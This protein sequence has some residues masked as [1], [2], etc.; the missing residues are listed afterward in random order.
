MAT[1]SKEVEGIHG[2]VIMYMYI[3]LMYI[4]YNYILLGL[5]ADKFHFQEKLLIIKLDY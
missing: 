3:G 2:M 4:L 1:T 5:T